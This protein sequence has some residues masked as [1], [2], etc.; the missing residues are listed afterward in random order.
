MRL[1][2]AAPA[3]RPRSARDATA[4]AARPRLLL[5][6]AVKRAL[7]ALLLAACAHHEQHQLEV[8]VGEHEDLAGNISARV[9]SAEHAHLDEHELVTTAPGERVEEH[10]APDGGLTDRVTTRWG[11][12]TSENW[13]KSAL[14]AEEHLELDAGVVERHDASADVRKSDR[15]DRTPSGGCMLGLGFWGAVAIAVLLAAGILYLRVVRPK[16]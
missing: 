13:L 11:G 14:N 12:S 5:G 6:A 10:F 8:H 4:D 16:L 1:R 7:L 2:H 3:S 15:L 9:D